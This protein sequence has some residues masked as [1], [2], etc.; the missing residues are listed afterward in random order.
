MNWE[1]IA[2]E[3]Y[4]KYAQQMRQAGQQPKTWEQLS[5]AEQGAWLLAAKQ[6]GLLVVKAFLA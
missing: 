6:V 4:I 1:A 2:E 5:T 3:G